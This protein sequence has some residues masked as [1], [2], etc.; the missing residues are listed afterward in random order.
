MTPS[1]P[2]S[3]QPATQSGR[4]QIPATVVDV[5]KKAHAR[6]A[7]KIDL[8]RA[9]HKPLSLL[10]QEAKRVLE[11]FLDAESPTLTRSDRDKL[12]D[13]V[14]AEG[15]GFGPLEELYRDE[16]IKE[17]LIL[18]ATQI[19][20]RKGDAW[21]PASVRLRDVEQLRSVITRYSETGESFVTGPAPTGGVD[22]R[23]AN[24]FRAVAVVPPQVMQVS[25]QLLL[26]RLSPA[27]AAAPT[28]N[29]GT[30]Q[31]TQV[32]SPRSGGSGAIHV[33]P[34]P[35]SGNLGPPVPVPASRTPTPTILADQP[36]PLPQSGTIPNP[37]PFAKI[38]QRMAEKIIM[39]FASAGVYDISAIPQAELRKI[40]HAT[41]IEVCHAE[42]LGYDEQF[43]ER[44]ALEIL[45]GMNR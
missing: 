14:L 30:V 34:G 24:G 40:V 26:T 4:Y 43:Q 17:I 11:Q 39:K 27:A 12:V 8:V 38:R 25:P 18:T 1:A 36:R 19:I 3:P 6:I 22:V 35:R 41:V 23:L 7:E 20:V 29:S 5:R 28:G 10:R 32:A 31:F 45:A 33:T 16:A 21:L 15:F 9:R 42:K 2:G 44:L 37:D 13:D